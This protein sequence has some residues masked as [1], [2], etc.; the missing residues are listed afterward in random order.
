METVKFGIIGTNFISDWMVNGG[1]RDPRFEAI[2][3][4]SRGIETG[5]A[6]AEKHGIPRVYTSLDAMLADD[7]VDV[8][9]VASPNSLHC[10]HTLA[11]L[12]AGKHVLCEKPVAANADEARMMYD[13]ARRC[14]LLLVE[15][16]IPTLSPVLQAVKANLY[17]VGQLR[18]YFASYCQYS[19]RYDNLKRGIVANAFK[20]ELANG[21]VMDIGVYCIS[22][23]VSLFGAPD[24]VFSQ[25]YRLSTGVDGQGTVVAGY[26]EFDG[27]AI[28]SKIADSHLSTEI[29]GEN[30]TITI[31][32]INSPRR[33]V[34]TPRDKSLQP[35]VLYEVPTDYDP[36]TTEIS[37]FI[38]LLEAGMIE[39]PLNTPSTSVATMTILDEVRGK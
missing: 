12:R 4:Y 17:K 39:S 24:T 8:V 25:C 6:F 29:Q 28:Y 23:M 2:A 32:H 27:V 34:F 14:N 1:R 10:R 11:A 13:E 5:N 26:K 15:A 33:A 3:V 37:H 19:S 38:D 21:A 7:E 16:M 22:P 9:Y 35:E 20:P 18:R 31:D 36:Y 30:G